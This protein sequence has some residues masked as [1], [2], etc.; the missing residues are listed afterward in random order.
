MVLHDGG[1]ED[2]TTSEAVNSLFC[3]LAVQ[4]LLSIVSFHV[5]VL[6]MNYHYG[7]CL[8]L[9]CGQHLLIKDAAIFV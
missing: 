9:H 2:I 4:S 6:S 1:N 8:T 3:M 7:V 5:A